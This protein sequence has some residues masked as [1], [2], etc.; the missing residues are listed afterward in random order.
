MKL[1][2]THKEIA[3]KKKRT[4]LVVIGIGPVSYTH[5]DV[6]KRQREI[7]VFSNISQS[8][9]SVPGLCSYEPWH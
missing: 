1:F 4:A 9:L 8:L 2:F 6:Y 5:L 7:H 3:L